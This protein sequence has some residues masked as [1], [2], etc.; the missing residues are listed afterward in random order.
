VRDEVLAALREV[1]LFADLTAAHLEALADAAT[2]QEVPAGTVITREGE[3]PSAFHVLVE[4]TIEWSR[5]TGADRILGARQVAPPVKFM[6]ATT[7]LAEEPARLNGR[8][9]APSR[10]VAVQPAALRAVVR[11]DDATFRR[12]VRL[13]APVARRIEATAR[14]REKLVALG[15]LAAGLAHEIGN[16]VAAARQAVGDL[17]AVVALLEAAG[18]LDPQMSAALRAQA[19]AGAGA[20][21]A[22]GALER[23]EREEALG[24]ALAARGVADAWGWAAR[25]APVGVD[26]AWVAALADAAPGDALPRA[27]AAVGGGLSAR[28]LLADVGE[29]LARVGELVGAVAEYAYLDRDGR[30]ELDVHAGLES[31]LAVLDAELR[32]AGVRVERDFAADVPPVEAAGSELTQVWTNLLRNAMEAAPGGT[33]RVRTRLSGDHV[34]VAVVDDGPGVPPELRDRIFEPFFTTKDVGAGGGLGLDAARRIVVD[35]HGGELRLDSR[36][37]E[38]EFSVLLPVLR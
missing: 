25:L 6:G 30:Q 27:L 22:L 14:Q 34:E 37:G 4:G 5:G 23:A 7:L 28:A 33:V 36:P 10:L 17:G 2:L 18:P 12:A 26:A 1:E 31:T 19:E 13:F 21:G 24:E 15:G 35:G 32:A 20:E 29:A 11:A 8:T 9:I 38:T 3:L 16:P